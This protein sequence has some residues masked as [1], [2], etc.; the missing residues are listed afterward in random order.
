METEVKTIPIHSME[1]VAFQLGQMSKSIEKIEV[2]QDKAA[3]ENRKNFDDIKNNYVSMTAFN[4]H[5]KK[6]DDHELRIRGLEGSDKKWGIGA[7]II[8]GGMGVIGSILI[9]HFVK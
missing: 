1:T 6:D 8:G 3:E 7:S 4:E 2:K 5:L 9:Q